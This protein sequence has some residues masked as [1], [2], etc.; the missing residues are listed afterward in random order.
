M[1]ENLNQKIRLKLGSSRGGISKE[2][3]KTKRRRR[4]TNN[5]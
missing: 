2:K 5:Q 4:K 3:N 1:A